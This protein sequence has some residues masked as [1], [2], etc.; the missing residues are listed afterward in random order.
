MVQELDF[1]KSSDVVQLLASTPFAGTH[2]DHVSSGANHI[3]RVHLTKPFEGHK[4]VIVKHAKVDAATVT[5]TTK[6]SLPLD[7]QDFEAAALRLVKE[8]MP[9]DGLVT[10]PTLYQHDKEAHVLIMEDCGPTSRNLKQVFLEEK[11]T[12][13]LA[14]TIGTELGSFMATLHKKGSANK[15]L[16]AMC[17]KNERMKEL[18]AWVTYGRLADTIVGKDIEGEGAVVDPPLT[19]NPEDL[20]TVKKIEEE[21]TK[22]I[23]ESKTAFTMGDFWTGN[24]VAETGRDA[25]GNLTI[26]RMFVVDWEVVKPGLQFLDIAQFAAELHTLGAFHPDKADTTNETLKALLTTYAKEMPLD[27]KDI[28]GAAVHVGAHLV[29]WT[30]R[31]TSW[32][33]KERVREVVAEGVE[34]LLKG[35]KGD[36][37]FLKASAVNHLLPTSN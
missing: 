21:T 34:Y 13:E 14:R 36:S 19:L 27:E 23:V 31:V 15:E 33:P 25:D 3:T 28:K 26:V 4:T 32:G 9:S 17:V 10:V 6:I 1:A 16:M 11:V 24:V 35:K 37:R 2:A 18:S 12:P 7:R 30:P 8:T 29:A 20:A 5:L 22:A